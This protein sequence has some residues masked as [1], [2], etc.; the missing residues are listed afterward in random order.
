MISL[1]TGNQRRRSIPALAPATKPLNMCC[2]LRSKKVDGNE[3]PGC[4]AQA[5]FRMKTAGYGQR[6]AQ[7]PITEGPRETPA[8]RG[9][10]GK[11]I[12][13]LWIATAALRRSRDDDAGSFQQPASGR[14]S[15]SKM[16]PAPLDLA[17]A[18]RPGRAAHPAAPAQTRPTS[19]AHGPSLYPGPGSSRPASFAMSARR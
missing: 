4:I 17:R 15:E 1:R 2:K 19:S 16:N 14:P 5:I 10:P 11:R 8:Q 12:V 18:F 9:D 3:S 7:W 6:I 13:V